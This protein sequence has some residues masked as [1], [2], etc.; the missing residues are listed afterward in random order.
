MSNVVPKVSTLSSMSG[1]LLGLMD[2]GNDGS[3]PSP[4]TAADVPSTP[5][6]PVNAP[7][8]PDPT[9]P[10][11]VTYGTGKPAKKRRK[12]GTVMTSAQGVMGS[13]P[14]DRKSLLGS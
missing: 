4:A 10:A 3:M 14:V 7:S 12:T 1:G 11:D 13:A 2:R 9:S 6:L 8:I 5:S